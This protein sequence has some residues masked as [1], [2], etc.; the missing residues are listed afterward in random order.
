MVEKYFGGDC[1]PAE[2]EA[3]ALDDELVCAMIK[4]TG[5]KYAG[6]DGRVPA[7]PRA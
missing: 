1:L 7:P 3:D 4:T 6:T 2:R 5:A